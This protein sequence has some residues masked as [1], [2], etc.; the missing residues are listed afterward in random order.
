MTSNRGNRI[1]Q[2]GKYRF[3]E[4]S[5]N[6]RSIGPKKRWGCNRSVKGCKAYFITVDDVVVKSNDEHNH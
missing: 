3:I 6:K 5:R 4:H 2:Y 1:I